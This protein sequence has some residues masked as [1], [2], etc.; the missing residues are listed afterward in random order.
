M[1]PQPYGELL[2][3][4]QELMKRHEASLEHLA[5]LERQA[6]ELEAR[7]ARLEQIANMLSEPS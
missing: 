4:Y 6:D 1:N 2:K 3:L 7:I 5:E